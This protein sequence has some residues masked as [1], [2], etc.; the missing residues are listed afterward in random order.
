MFILYFFLCVC[1]SSSDFPIAFSWYS[2]VY[3]FLLYFLVILIFPYFLHYSCI[4]QLFFPSPF[5]FNPTDYMHYFLLGIP[6]CFLWHL[7]LLFKG[8]ML[9]LIHFCCSCVLCSIYVIWFS[10]HLT[11]FMVLLSVFLCMVSFP[12]CHSVFTSFC[13]FLHISFHSFSYF[14]YFFLYLGHT[15]CTEK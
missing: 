13:F 12:I 15:I 7:L 10:W 2:T 14:I 3:L 8:D 4:L 1:V 9:S 6:L 11:W 5:H